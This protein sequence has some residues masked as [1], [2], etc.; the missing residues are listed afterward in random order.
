MVITRNEEENVAN[1]LESVFEVGDDHLH[2]VIL[3]D[4]NSSDRTVE[5]AEEY[6]VTIARITDDE[7]VTPSAGRYVGGRLA[8]GE[9]VLFV[10][11]DV[12]LVDGWLESALEVLQNDSNVGGVSGHLDEPPDATEPERVNRI[13]V[14]MLFRRDVLEEEGGFDPFMK[15]AE[16]YELSYRLVQRG[17]DLVKLPKVVAIHPEGNLI[18]GQIQSVSRGYPYGNG[19]LIR[20]FRSSPSVLASYLWYMRR[21]VTA[22]SWLSVGLFS[23]VSDRRAA[24]SW[25]LAT[26]IGY[27]VLGSRKGWMKTAAFPMQS[28]LRIGYI[29]LGVLEEPPNA[30]SFPESVVEVYEERTLSRSTE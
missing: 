28:C 6:P 20:R 27:V 5:I 25:L 13:K 2:E 4:S 19:Q 16:D 14:V 12:E 18:R 24:A 21:D 22:V 3:V 7:Y 11:G 8:D 1:C 10:D 15:G 17:Y 23:V 26:A 30:S 9:Y 29:V